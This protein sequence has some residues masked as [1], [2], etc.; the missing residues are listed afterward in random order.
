[1]YD[2]AS[3]SLTKQWGNLF[4]DLLARK[5]DCLFLRLIL[6]IYKNQQCNVRWCDRYSDCF[7]VKNGVR[8]EG[9]TSGIF[10]AVYI[11]ELLKILRKSGLGCHINGIF[12]GAVIFADDIFLLSASRNGLQVMV[13]M[14]S[15]FASS[16]NLTFGTN[17]DQEKSKTKCI[18]LSKKSKLNFQAMNISLNGDQLPWVKS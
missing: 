3:S 17:V 9:V 14:C 7:N 18:I 2:N 4:E 10:F 16:R 15:Q 1:M 8:Q 5:V 13:D 12:Y 6:Y 11:N